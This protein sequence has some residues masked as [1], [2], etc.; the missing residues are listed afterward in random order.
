M[1]VAA[2]QIE[3]KQSVIAAVVAYGDTSIKG[4]TSD[5]GDRRP[6]RG[7]TQDVMPPR[8]EIPPEAATSVL[9]S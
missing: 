2:M 6:V 1:T 9:R 4:L 3:P 8:N 7:R 5:A